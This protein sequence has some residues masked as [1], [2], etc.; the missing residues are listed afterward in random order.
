MS[1]VTSGDHRRDSCKTLISG[2]L[3]RGLRLALLPM[4]AGCLIPQSV[5][6]IASREHQPP[7]IAV[8][9]I[10][11]YLLAPLL[12]LMQQTS[13]DVTDGCHCRIDLTVP[14]IEEDDPTVDLLARWFVDYDLAVPRSTGVVKEQSFNGSFNSQD[15]VRGP[16]TF[17]FELDALGITDNQ[18]HVVEV[19]VGERS[20]FDE[21][22]TA[23]PHRAMLSGYSSTIYKFVI[24]VD[25][26]TGTTCP[27]ELPS[28]RVRTDGTSCQ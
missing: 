6:P 21:E 17:N 10:P 1:R 15:I 19:V 16:A 2:M 9:S 18:A 3:L 12:P 7:R 4:L 23:L 20:G 26:P 27:S 14:Q 28:R 13:Q 22:S 25:P 11:S 24:K 5:D 8:E